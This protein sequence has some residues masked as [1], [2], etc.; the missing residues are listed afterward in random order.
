MDE[1]EAFVRRIYLIVR[2][3]D[4][5][6]YKGGQGEESLITR[7]PF[8]LFRHPLRQTLSRISYGPWMLGFIS[9]SL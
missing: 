9:G 6:E 2:I 4:C 7:V 5:L 1:C 3:Q 8:G